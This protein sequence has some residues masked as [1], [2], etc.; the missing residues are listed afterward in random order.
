MHYEK[1]EALSQ[2]LKAPRRQVQH[3][4]MR[5]AIK[6]HQWRQQR[7]SIIGSYGSG[8]LH[9]LGG[10]ITRLMSVAVRLVTVTWRRWL[11]ERRSKEGGEETSKEG[12]KEASAL[13]SP[14]A[15]V[16]DGLREKAPKRDDDATKI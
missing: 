13:A 8:S 16:D 6:I 11:H 2:V 3:G 1:G 12:G 9:Q 7:V 4:K 15:S 5:E 14:T 10:G